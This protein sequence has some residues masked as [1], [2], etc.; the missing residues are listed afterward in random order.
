MVK[1]KS[2]VHDLHK[3]NY[4]KILIIIESRHIIHDCLS[5]SNVNLLM[6]ILRSYYQMN[7]SEY[8]DMLSFFIDSVLCLAFPLLISL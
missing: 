4:G 2:Y 3:D 6:V 5:F 1:K 7:V 8:G